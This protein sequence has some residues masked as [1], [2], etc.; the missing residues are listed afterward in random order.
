[1]AE[2]QARRTR[3]P[4][5]QHLPRRGR[6]DHAKQYCIFEQLVRVGSTLACLSRGSARPNIARAP[7]SDERKCRDLE[8]FPRI[9]SVMR[10]SLGTR[11][12]RRIIQ[13]VGYIM[14]KYVPRS[15]GWGAVGCGF[16][17]SATLTEVPDVRD[18]DTVLGRPIMPQTEIPDICSQ[19]S[20]RL[21][22]TGCCQHGLL[23]LAQATEMECV[24]RDQQ[25]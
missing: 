13:T 19:R 2:A 9:L 3:R 5:L 7:G 15:T 14:S 17:A 22:N 6:P 4:C 12:S 8:L 24:K 23:R 18:D 20:R 16:V 10:V 21:P 25:R 1:V 11:M